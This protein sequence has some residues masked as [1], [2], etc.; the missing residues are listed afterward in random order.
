MVILCWFVSSIAE[1]MISL[2]GSMYVMFGIVATFA[3]FPRIM[4]SGV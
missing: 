3:R 4:L 1:S 2:V